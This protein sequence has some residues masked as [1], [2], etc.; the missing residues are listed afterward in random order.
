M[1]KVSINGPYNYFK[2]T[3]GEKT[4]CL[5]SDV[6]NEP[7]NQTECVNHENSVDIDHFLKEFLINSNKSDKEYDLF[8]E[9]EYMWINSKKGLHNYRDGYLNRVRKLF[10]KNMDFDLSKNKIIKSSNYDNVR[11][12]YFDFRFNT[13]P[14]CNIIFDLDMLVYPPYDSNTKLLKIIYIIDTII[15]E[16]NSF[17]NNI[18]KKKYKYINKTFNNYSNKKIKEKINFIYKN[19]T[20]KFIDNIL[21]ICDEIKTDIDESHTI[22]LDKYTN[23]KIKFEL[24]TKIYKKMTFIQNYILYGFSTCIDLYFIRRILDKNY[25]NNVIS[26]MGGNHVINIIFFLVKYFNFEITECFYNIHNYDIK[27]I[28]DVFKENVE[29][30]N[31]YPIF[32][33]FTSQCVEINKNIF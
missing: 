29:S 15:K 16:Y 4:I 1:E 3:N 19:H 33:N 23:N 27:K 20:S 22:L 32:N 11:F 31:I 5:F 2:L 18:K 13:I 8:I 6:H 9:H 12:H 14:E 17:K 28:N 25:I 7:V 24:S 10:N 21:D 30:Y 26:Y